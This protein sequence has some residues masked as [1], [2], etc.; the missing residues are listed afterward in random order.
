MDNSTGQGAARALVGVLFGALLGFAVGA[1]AYLV[2]DAVLEGSGGWVEELQGLA[3]NVVP[4]GTV[5][6]AGVGVFVTRRR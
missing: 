4:L 5:V 6:G 2:I 3:W 1:A